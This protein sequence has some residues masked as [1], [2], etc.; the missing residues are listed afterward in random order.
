[1]YKYLNKRKAIQTNKA[2]S[3]LLIPI[4]RIPP[5]MLIAK[6]K[7][8]FYTW[9]PIFKNRKRGGKGTSFNSN[10]CSSG[11]EGRALPSS[12]GLMSI[13]VLPDFR[14]LFACQCGGL[15]IFPIR[16]GGKGLESRRKEKSERREKKGLAL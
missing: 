5:Q 15:Y 9:E 6:K 11:K 14:S 4:Q 2:N 3:T 1:M 13:F 12:S 16:N 8:M 10:L 7:K